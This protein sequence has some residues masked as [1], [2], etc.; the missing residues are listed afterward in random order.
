MIL[1]EVSIAFLVLI[2]LL[3][4]KLVVAEFSKEG[5]TLP[6]F[7]NF[8]SVQQPT[9]P[10]QPTLKAKNLAEMI[11]NLDRFPRLEHTSHTMSLS[12]LPPNLR[13]PK[14]RL[15]RRQKGTVYTL[16]K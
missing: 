8:P 5:K 4:F 15:S 11:S 3:D 2:I 1:R 14:P 13:N 16:G 10:F 6:K 9:Y 7:L 12:E